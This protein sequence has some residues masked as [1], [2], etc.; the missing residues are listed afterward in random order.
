M[1]RTANIEAETSVLG[2][3]LLDGTLVHEL[4]VKPEHFTDHR[5]QRIFQAMKQVASQG[6]FIDMVTLTTHLGNAITEIGG[7]TYLLAMAESVASTQSLKHHEQLIFAAY[8][9]R[10]AQKL[11]LSFAEHP[12]EAELDTLI[13]SLQ[14]YREIGVNN[15]EK[16]TYDHLLKITEEMCFPTEEQA[17]FA[18]SFTDLDGMTGGLQRG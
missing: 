15:L 12:S 10:M 16:T 4:S 18:T 17:G 9:N 5:H 3:V 2:S 7:T 6:K 11:A 1:T 13:S 14:A 8:R